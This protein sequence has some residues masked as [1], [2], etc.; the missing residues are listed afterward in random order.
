MEVHALAQVEAIAQAVVGHRPALG[1]RGHHRPLGQRVVLDHVEALGAGL[2]THTQGGSGGG[3]GEQQGGEEQG[4]S[5]EAHD[6]L[7]SNG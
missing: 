3:L 5:G 1:Q 6:G 2:G 7:H 4:E